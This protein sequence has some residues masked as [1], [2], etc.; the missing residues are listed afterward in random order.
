[1]KEPKFKVGD[2]IVYTKYER[3]HQGAR[4]AYIVTQI[5]A[6]GRTYAKEIGDTRTERGF[7]LSEY[8]YELEG[9]ND[10]PST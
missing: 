7:L 1:M 10:I 6:I 3:W 9:E 4:P 2:R 5:D 8:A